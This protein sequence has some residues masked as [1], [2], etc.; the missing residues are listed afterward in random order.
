MPSAPRHVEELLTAAGDVVDR[1][2]AQALGGDDDVT[3]Q[4]LA[5][6]D[7]AAAQVVAVEV[8]E[9]KGAK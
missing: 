5:V 8:E 2:D 3:Q 4:L 6:L 1:D 9:V 7:R